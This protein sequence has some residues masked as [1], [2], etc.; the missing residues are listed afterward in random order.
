MKRIVF[1]GGGTGGHV[2]PGLAVIEALPEEYRARVVWIGTAKGVEGPIVRGANIQGRPIPFES[3]PSGKLRRYFDLKNLTDLFRIIAGIIKAVV[4]LG[5]LE[6]EIVFSKGGFVSVPVVVAAALRRLPVIIHESDRTPGLATRISAPLA[7]TICVPDSKSIASFPTR[8]HPRVIVTGNPV[9][10][11]FR[12]ATGTEVLK[13]LSLPET[14]D[15]VVFVTGGSLGARQLNRWIAETIVKLS[16]R[17]VIIHQTGAHGA[18]LIREIAGDADEGRYYGA[19]SFSELFPEILHRADLVVARAGAG[20]IWEI[21]TVGRPA[22]LVPLS[23]EVS[24]GDQIVNAHAF[25]ESGAA[26]VID[27]PDASASKLLE[28]VEALLDDPQR[29]ELMKSAAQRW[30]RRNGADEISR[31]IVRTV[32]LLER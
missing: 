29:L 7:T 20:T 19:P 32:A 5:R 15:P 25:A 24:R 9:R 18:E 3:V 12:T 4:L 1:T 14:T 27:D 28:T 21:A 17:A 23:K 31:L 11:V 16:R 30:G 22:I 2:Y 8:L 13:R 6:T 10:A 26:I